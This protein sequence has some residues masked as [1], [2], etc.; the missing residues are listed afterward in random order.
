MLDKTQTTELSNFISDMNIDKLEIPT[1]KQ[2]EWRFT[3]L[4]FLQDIHFEHSQKKNT[5]LEKLDDKLKSNNKHQ[6][7]L[8]NNV[9]NNNFMNTIDGLDILNMNSAINKYPEIIKTHFSKIY[10]Y[11]NDYFCTKNMLDIDDGIFIYVKKDSI[12][13]LPL[14]IIFSTINTQVSPRIFVYC[15]SNSNFS[16]IEKYVSKDGTESFTNAITEIYL[17]KN[18][19][20]EYVKIQTESSNSIHFSGL[21]IHQENDSIITCHTFTKETGFTRNNIFSKLNGSNSEC[22]LN[23]LSIG[24]K[25]NFIDNHSIIQHSAPHSISSELYKGI[26]SDASKGVFDG[27]IIVDDNATKI[28]S[29]QLNNNILLSEDASV[30]SNPRLE[31]N[32]DDV[33]CK[34][35]STTGQLENEPLFYLKSRGFNN[36]RAQKIL[37]QGFCSEFIDNINNQEICDDFES[38]ITSYIN[39]I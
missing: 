14:E 25:S 32:T 24:N 9:I 11:K 4:N 20:L 7:Y 12:I 1:S 29:E 37:L 22:R 2:E 15:S 5:T 21:G 10:R 18:S 19:N 26:Y 6:I 31:I 23:G 8:N 28:D 30:N 33:T 27:K 39:N 34:H 36:D 17:E 16:L 38:I 3:N 35:G 13:T